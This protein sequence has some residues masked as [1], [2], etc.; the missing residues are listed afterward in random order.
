MAAVAVM[1]GAA[2]GAMTRHAIARIASGPT[3]TLVAN[4]VGSFLLGVVVAYGPSRSWAL[5]IGTGFCGA[6]TTMSSLMLEATERYGGERW[7]LIATHLVGGLMLAALGALTG[8][9]LVN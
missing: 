8:S 5:L 6:L 3:A 1:T 2:L 7:R 9:V 4:L